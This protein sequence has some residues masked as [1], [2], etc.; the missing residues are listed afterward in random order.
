ML[1]REKIH[2]FHEKNPDNELSARSLELIDKKG[3]TCLYRDCF[4]DGH[5]VWSLFVFNP[6]MT[7]MLMMHHVKL[8]RWLQFGGHADGNPDLLD[9]SIREFHEESWSTLSPTLVHEEIIDIDIHQ[10]PERWEEPSHY[11]YDIRFVATLPEDTTLSFQQEEAHDVR[12][13]DLENI[14]DFT[15]EES[16]LRIVRKIS[17]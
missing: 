9:T 5:F 6:Q 15:T 8:G 1:I 7:K 11:H 14:R 16:V 4:D 12:W 10:I 17:S 3:E 2:L 13:V